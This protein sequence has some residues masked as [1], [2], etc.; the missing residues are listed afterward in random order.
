M[1]QNPPPVQPPG[2]AGPFMGST[3]YGG[4]YGSGYS[5]QSMQAG[6]G[7]A[8]AGARAAEYV[9]HTLI[10]GAA[11][12]GLLVAGIGGPLLMYGARSHGMKALG[13]GLNQF[14][15][16]THM[17]GI[18][19]GIFQSMGGGGSYAALSGAARGGAAGM[20]GLGLARGAFHAAR[21]GMAATGGVVGGV[22]IPLA[23]TW[24]MTEAVSRAGEAVYTGAQEKLT[25]TALM[26]SMGGQFGGNAGH[27]GGVGQMLGDVGRDVGKSVGQM[28]DLTRDMDRMKMFQTTKDVKEFKERFKEI[29]ST[30][31][32]VAQTMQT[33]IDDALKM[34]GEM[35]TQGFYTTAD[36]KAGALKQQARSSASGL[37]QGQLAAAGQ[38]GSQYARALG[39][40]GRF[41][42]DFAQQQTSAVAY[43]LRQGFMS[44]E[45]IEERGG[46]QAVGA[47]LAATQMRF[48]KSS[49]G[50]V[51]I[52]NMLGDGSDLDPT[53]VNNFLGKG[54]TLEGMVTGA[55]GRGLGTLSTAG[56]AEAR[57]NAAQYA[58]MGMVS[59]A[60][61]Q[62]KQLGM[63]VNEQSVLRMLG[64]MGVQR[65]DAELLLKQTL[66]MGSYL[67]QER[68]GEYNATQRAAY[69]DY[70]QYH[71]FGAGLDRFTDRNGGRYLRG[72]GREIYTDGAQAWK[73]VTG[74]FG[75]GTAFTG[76]GKGD[77]ES[78]RMYD[79]LGDSG[80]AL[81]T[82]EAF[83]LFDTVDTI[84]KG[85][86][87]RGPDRE[88]MLRTQL[89]PLTTEGNL[90]DDLLGAQGYG[91]RKGR[92]LGHSKW[93]TKENEEKGLRHLAETEDMTHEQAQALKALKLTA[94]SGSL[95]DHAADILKA[96][97]I[98][99]PGAWR[100]EDNDLYIA[101]AIDVQT[102]AYGKPGEGLLGGRG[103]GDSKR[104][105]L[106]QIRLREQ[107]AREGV[108]NR[109]EL[110][111]LKL[112][113]LAEE[114]ERFSE[115][116]ESSLA[117]LGT[118][119]GLNVSQGWDLFGGFVHYDGTGKEMMTALEGNEDSRTALRR[120]L[121]ALQDP[122]ADPNDVTKAVLAMGD[123][124]GSEGMIQLAERHQS[125]EIDLTGDDG[126]SL[127]G[128]ILRFGKAAHRDRAYANVASRA[129]SLADSGEFGE[130]STELNRLSLVNKNYE[131]DSR[132]LTKGIIQSDGGIS[133]TEKGLLGHLYG[134]VGSNFSDRIN[135]IIGGSDDKELFSGL[136]LTDDQRKNITS[137]DGEERI[138]A[139]VTAL[140]ESK[141]LDLAGLTS[142]GGTD[143]DGV[144]KEYVEANTQ[145]VLAVHN[146]IQNMGMDDY[147]KKEVELL[148][149]TA[150]D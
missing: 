142:E 89:A 122:D 116:I 11:S 43:G 61:A 66:G 14:D 28:A 9:G 91:T 49:R 86:F 17:M 45:D 146:F 62:A 23:A 64:T 18:G 1:Y 59:I 147:I 93:I 98:E 109:S 121:Q 52:A 124:E 78:A 56:G 81:G 141:M 110:G 51:M 117:G 83:G 54:M 140:E 37:G 136:N 40:R 19:R 94:G 35:K 115:D 125:G 32:E 135:S 44:E 90:M 101:A 75:G 68:K 137:K 16:T 13:A 103:I 123:V 96:N 36:I 76:G 48:M 120:Y 71:S 73:S 4:Q 21:L 149:Q 100:K 60:G 57:E 10:P 72:K 82:R 145:F 33:S 130:F 102:G 139:L 80:P 30:V 39:M 150:G 112:G 22:G 84:R 63:G 128:S 5:Q 8:M 42:S 111:L 27:G 138:D 108:G 24:A 3:G 6:V 70:K 129:G 58:G 87:G 77:M 47:N 107:L 105:G 88:E 79:Q 131:E 144:R 126:K 85:G 26:S 132:A 97:N 41:G 118:Q 134:K 106:Q 95:V 143:I 148:K 50:R 67:E 114:K 104:T 133:D 55:A 74:L 69:E 38:F 12:A 99:V 7:S 34:V 119:K 25:G 20:R 15:P 127:L 2:L 31:K 113:S 92:A 46:V 65:P 29:M 53:R